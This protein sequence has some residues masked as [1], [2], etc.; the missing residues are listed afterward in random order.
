MEA[1]RKNFEMRRTARSRLPSSPLASR[2]RSAGR[3]VGW[4]WRH[5][6]LKSLNLRLE[7]APTHN[8]H[9]TNPEMGDGEDA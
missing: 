2:A 4:K 5:K 1:F 6:R 9:P 7:M 8:N 3:G